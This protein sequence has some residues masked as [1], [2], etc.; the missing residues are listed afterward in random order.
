MCKNSFSWGTFESPLEIPSPRPGIH[1][2]CTSLKWAI[3]PSP[4]YSLLACSPPA[5][6]VTLSLL[7]RFPLA[8]L[9]LSHRNLPRLCCAHSGHTGHSI[10]V[11]SALGPGMSVQASPHSP[12]GT[13]RSST[14]FPVFLTRG[15]QGMPPG[16]SLP[17]PFS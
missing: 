6:G 8:G 10:T 13:S 9:H 17:A 12:P 14:Y 15:P 3:P 2:F 16:G 11:L 5:V 7:G 1:L 4:G